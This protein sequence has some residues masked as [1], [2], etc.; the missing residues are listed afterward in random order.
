[1]LYYIY[2][3]YDEE[4]SHASFVEAV[5]EYRK[6]LHEEKKSLFTEGGNWVNPIELQPE[7]EDILIKNDIDNSNKLSEGKYNEEEQNVYKNNIR[8]YL[9]KQLIVGEIEIQN[10]KKKKRVQK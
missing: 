10:Q 8:D 1:M 2:F 5:N 7:T 9:K 6:S 3:Q 4:K